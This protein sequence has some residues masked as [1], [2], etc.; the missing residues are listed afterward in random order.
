MLSHHLTMV[1]TLRHHTGNFSSALFDAQ[2][3][4]RRATGDQRG[5]KSKAPLGAHRDPVHR[6][7]R[8]YTCDPQTRGF[9]GIWASAQQTSAARPTAGVASTS[10]REEAWRQGMGQQLK[11]AGQ[12]CHTA[13]G[14][15]GTRGGVMPVASCLC[16]GGRVFVSG[17]GGGSI[18]PSGRTPL[19]QCCYNSN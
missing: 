5:P 1:V 10:F 7:D 13:G 14:V 11:G 2:S 9:G 15:V 19:T 6:Q 17:G 18:E 12:V 16:W 4:P 8:T 3:R